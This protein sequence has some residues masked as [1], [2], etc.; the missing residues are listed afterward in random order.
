MI[1]IIWHPKKFFP[2]FKYKWVKLIFSLVNRGTISLLG[3]RIENHSNS[4]MDL[5][6]KVK[7]GDRNM[8][9]SEALFDPQDNFVN[10]F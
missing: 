2:L 7:L 6:F 4:I 8:I 3:L 10:V 1:H 5:L 9:L